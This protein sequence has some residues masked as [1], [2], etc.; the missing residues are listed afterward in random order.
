MGERNQDPH[1]TELIVDS[2]HFDAVASVLAGDLGVWTGKPTSADTEEN[3]DLALVLLKNLQLERYAS[4]ARARYQNEID[5]LETDERKFKPL[6]ILLYDLRAR[7]TASHGFVPVMGKN[8]EAVIGYP[9]HKGVVNPQL[10]D[11][12]FELAST[13]AGSG[14]RIGVVDTRL[15]PHKSLPLEIVLRDDEF[16]VG[17]EDPTVWAGHATFIAGLIRQAAPGAQLDMRAGLS[18]VTG[19]SSA[20]EAA[21]KVASY[22]NSDIDI[23]NL[24]FGCETADNEP[25][26]VLRRALDRLSDSVLV[27]AAAGNRGVPESESE[28]EPPPNEIWPAAATSVIAVGVPSTGESGSLEDAAFSM[29]RRWVDCTAPGVNQ[30]SSY[31]TGP[32]NREPDRTETFTG[33]AQWSGTSFAAANVS[34]EVAAQMTRGNVGARDALEQLM[35]KQTPSIQKYVHGQ[36]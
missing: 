34:G 10:T 1:P 33:F 15:A 6:D 21:K 17:T 7:F 11:E 14:V 35:A 20:W 36:S 18:D 25:P 19:E 27:V 24:S 29:R 16:K 2:R 8:R 30:L 3:E 22:R 9:Q 31:L 5:A 4:R 23:L 32:V 12:T 13:G 28:S 26:L